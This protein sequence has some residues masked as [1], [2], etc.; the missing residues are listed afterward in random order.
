MI[1]NNEMIISR[2]QK[3]TNWKDWSLDGVKH[4]LENIFIGLFN[5][6]EIIKA[7]KIAHQHDL[8]SIFNEC[9][10]IDW[11]YTDL[12]GVVHVKNALNR[13]L[14]LNIEDDFK[15]VEIDPIYRCGTIYHKDVK[16]GMKNVIHRYTDLVKAVNNKNK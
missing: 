8:E 16:C 7:L 12:D 9:G 11:L 4:V 5:Q 14:E 2:G 13:I 15:C 6:E 10:L 3:A 1:F